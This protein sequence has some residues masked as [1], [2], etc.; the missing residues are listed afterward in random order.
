MTK[1]DTERSR[2]LAIAPTTRGF[3]FAVLEDGAI[4][5]NWGIRS[6]E[7]DKNKQSV[8]KVKQLITQ[9]QPSLFVLQ[10][11]KTSFRRSR[12]RNL[13][14]KLI[15]V[16]AANKVKVAFISLEQVRLGL[17]TDGRGTKDAVAEAL[18]KKFPQELT[19][20]LPKKRN[21]PWISEQYNMGIFDAL[22]LA[23]TYHSFLGHKPFP[24][25]P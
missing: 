21:R 5:V 3:G 2:I 1:I 13:S 18:V 14:Q 15:G 9:Y 19:P 24:R 6:A 20:R 4:L 10:D 17:L 23:V 22:A 25:R 7:G 8:A 11:M 12:V 16:A